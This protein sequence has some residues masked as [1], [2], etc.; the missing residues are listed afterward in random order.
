MGAREVVERAARQHAD[1]A[2]AAQHRLRDAVDRTVTSGGNDRAAGLAG[3]PHRLA[4]RLGQ[5]PR[6]FY[7]QQL[8]TA[9]GGEAGRFN[10][11]PQLVAVAS[12][13]GA[14]EHHKQG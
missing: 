1:M 4:R 3:S 7:G 11:R 12:P 6:L 8:A 9:P 2:P 13:G 14:V 10:G 5:A